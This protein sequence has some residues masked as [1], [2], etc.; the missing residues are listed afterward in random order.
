MKR[1]HSVGGRVD[2]EVGIGRKLIIGFRAMI[3]DVKPSTNLD[4]HYHI[5]GP[6]VVTLK[7]VGE[8]VS[9]LLFWKI[10]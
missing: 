7:P 5:L 8:D 3:V 10:L 6:A 9:F 2:V 1:G 4:D